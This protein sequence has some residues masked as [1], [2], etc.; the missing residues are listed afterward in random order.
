MKV[1]PTWEIK[2]WRV[3][4]LDNLELLHLKSHNYEYPAHM[5]EEYSIALVLRGSETT[6]CRWGSH[7]A[8]AEDLL[9]INADEVHSSKSVAVEYRAIKIKTKTIDKISSGLFPIKRQRPYFPELITKDPTLFRSLLNL[10]LKLEREASF[11]EQE[12]EFVSAISL[13]LA[14]TATPRLALPRAGKE[15]R[16]VELVRDYLK[17]NYAQNVSLADLT[18]ITSLSHFYLLRAFRKQVGCPPHEYQTQLRIAHA[19]KLLREGMAVSSVAL[20]TGFF[21]QSH[22]SRNFKRIV[23]IPPGYYSTQSKIV[24]DAQEK[25]W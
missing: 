22:F 11:L 2:S 16:S 17:T 24:Q 6:T 19:R 3:R 9:L 5:H 7:T 18:S 21:D 12:S 23:G 4:G 25:I 15:S 10:H 13:L 14:R 8:F 20:E 1:R